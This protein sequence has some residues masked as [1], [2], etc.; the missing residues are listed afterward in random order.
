[1]RVC[2]CAQKR[3][4][5][6]YGHATTSSRRWQDENKETAEPRQPG[7]IKQ[8][9]TAKKG[10]VT[11]EYSRQRP[12]THPPVRG[13]RGLARP[14]RG[15]QPASRVAGIFFPPALR[16]DVPQRLLTSAAG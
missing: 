8:P 15:L 12:P 2:P 13:A 6:R 11:N 9:P 7:Q 16:P 10:P 3:R 1:M 14:Q 5:T 4:G